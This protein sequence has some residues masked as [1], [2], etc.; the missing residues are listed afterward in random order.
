MG[1]GGDDTT[2]VF[3]FTGFSFMLLLF[4]LGGVGWG[5]VG[6]ILHMSFASLDFL[7]HLVLRYL[8]LS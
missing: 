1:R 6:M 3:C 5:G 2:H 8:I 7:L 4:L